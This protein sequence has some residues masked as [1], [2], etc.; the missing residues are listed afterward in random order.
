[1]KWNEKSGNVRNSSKLNLNKNLNQTKVNI[2]SYNL[3]KIFLVLA[4]IDKNFNCFFISFECITI[5][6]FNRRISAQWR[7]CKLPVVQILQKN[8][9]NWIKVKCWSKIKIWNKVNIF[10]WNSKQNFL[11]LF[12]IDKNIKF[13]CISFSMH[14][15]K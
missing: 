7:D 3:N 10:G 5:G 11:L 15:S 8:H 2:F 13:V 9:Q 1:M 4:E 14:Q 12:K 6:K